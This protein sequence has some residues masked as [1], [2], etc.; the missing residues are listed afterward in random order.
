MTGLASFRFVA[1]CAEAGPGYYLNLPRLRTWI[2]TTADGLVGNT[3]TGPDVT[4]V[5]APISVSFAHVIAGGNTTVTP[6]SAGMAPPS[7]FRFGAPPVWYDISTTAQYVAPIVVCIT[8]DAGQ[9]G[10]PS[11]V[12]LFHF[13]NGRWVDRTVS[14]DEANR[15][16]CGSVSSL[17]P[18]ALA[19]PIAI[20][21]KMRG[22]GGFES[23]GK[24]YEFEF[25]VAERKL[26][27]ERGWMELEIRTPKHGKKKTRVDR[28]ES[29][30]VDEIFF[31][32]D[33]AF[34]PSR[35]KKT[36]P[37]ADSVMF[38]GT[39]RW[40]GSRGYTFEARAADAVV[41]TVD[42]VIDHGNIQSDRLD[43]RHWR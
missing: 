9:F 15:V 37:N 2:T 14:I 35:W 38:T 18:F 31:W 21:G 36:R 41:A 25:Q 13:E 3:P 11:A 39:G 5:N 12:K 22:D 7:G 30:G 43:P 17:S 33:P 23:G 1:T 28:F 34:R 40:N 16:V 20:E 32:D 26:G 42:E 10:N 27:R 19:E 4:V 24:A 6:Q 8:Y 29:T